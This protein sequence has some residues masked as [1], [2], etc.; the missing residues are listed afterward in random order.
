MGMF[1]YVYYTNVIRE[2][3]VTVASILQLVV[4]GLSRD[5][6]LDLFRKLG[7]LVGKDAVTI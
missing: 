1:A 5:E 6:Q 4:N 2:N 3:E 7:K